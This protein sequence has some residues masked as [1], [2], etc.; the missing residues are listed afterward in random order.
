MRIHKLHEIIGKAVQ[1]K[2]PNECLRD[3]A[4][5]GSGRISFFW[6]RKSNA[7]RFWDADIA[8]N[9]NRQIVAIV[10]VEE[11]NVKPH[12]LCGKIMSALLTTH[13]I[14]G[15]KNAIEIPQSP[16]MKFIQVV[17]DRPKGSKKEQWTNLEHTIVDA[18]KRW[19]VTMMYKL[20]V[21]EPGKEQECAKQVVDALTCPI[22]SR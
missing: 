2:F 8:L 18:I 20:I 3:T 11:S 4:C 7:T 21:C 9:R 15:G 10:E 16:Q 22:S 14:K 13:H 12:Q 19:G 17:T 1:E 5:G 6:Q